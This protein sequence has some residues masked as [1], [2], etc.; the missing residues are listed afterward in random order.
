MSAPRWL[1]VGGPSFAGAWRGVV[2]L[3]EAEAALNDAGVCSLLASEGVE[4]VHGRY[5]TDGEAAAAK[6]A[7]V[8]GG[9]R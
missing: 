1:V 2:E 6:A 9:V 5:A 3:T 8:E 7:W 4:R